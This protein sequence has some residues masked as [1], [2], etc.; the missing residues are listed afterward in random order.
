MADFEFEPEKALAVT[1]YLAEQSGQTMYTILKMIYVADRMH[2]ERYGR[3]ITGDA[4]IAMLQGACPSKIYDS[5]KA[6]RGDLNTNFLPE[7]ASYLTVD[8]TTHD[9]DVVKRPPMDVLSASDVECLE[10]TIVILKNRGSRHM[11]DLAHDSVWKNTAKNTQMGT[12][13]IAKYT[14][15]GDAL[16]SHLKTKFAV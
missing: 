9:V 2:L 5:M 3:P 4:Y 16:V 13:E 15:D 10:Q 14:Q 11:R 6:L 12:L 1:A 8:A 7:S